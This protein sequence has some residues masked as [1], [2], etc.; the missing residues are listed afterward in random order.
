MALRA[1]KPATVQKRLKALFYGNSGAGKTTAAINFP[2]PYLIDTEKGST[3]DQYV[4]TLTKNGGVVFHTGDFDELMQ[5]VK[6][7]LTEKHEYKT[8]IIDPLTTLYA[9]LLEK[10]ASKRISKLDPDGTS[11]GGHYAEANKKIKHLLN[12][13][14]RLDMNV[15]ITSHAK[16]EYGSNM[17]VLG[18]TFDCY[19]KLDY[20][21][22]LVFEVQKRGKER[23]GFIKKT[24]IESFPDGETFPFSYDEIA[25]R[26]GREVLERDAVAE[27]LASSEQV[28]RLKVL[29]DLYKEPE[30]VVQKWLDKANAE[31]LDEMNESIIIKLITHMEN[32]SKAQGEVA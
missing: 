1:V 13:L 7:L 26:Y 10:S 3:N 2:R 23:I 12:L 5:E 28:G 20:L 27:K 17:A 18:Q 25:E 22:D 30:E 15:I 24:R 9:D 6:S 8:L 21:F 19:K 31:T 4:K 32:K 16:N 14:V 11:Y 29:I